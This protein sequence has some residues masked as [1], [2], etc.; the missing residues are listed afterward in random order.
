MN[1][2]LSIV[3][4]VACAT[5]SSAAPNEP[6]PTNDLPIVIAHR[7][8]SGYLPEHTL[9]AKSLAFGQGADFLEQDVVLSKDGVPVV[10]HDIYLDQVTDVAS[11]FADRKRKDGRF[12]AIDFTVAE[13]KE[14]QI[15]ERSS[16]D[17][18]VV[19]PNRFPG[20]APLKMNTLE[21]ELQLIEG[22]NRSSGRRIGIYPEIKQ[23][24][25]HLQQGQD[26]SAK[27]IGVLHQ[28]GYR[29]K[30]DP[31]WLQ[32]FEWNEVQRLRS[33]LGW[34][35]RLVQLIGNGKTGSGESD[36]ESMKTEEGLK[37]LST[38]VDA[39]GP[40]IRVIIRGETIAARKLS[41]FIQ[42][43]HRHGLQVH[44]FTARADAL[45]SAVDSLDQ[46]HQLLLVD[47]EADGLFTDF[48]DRTAEFIQQ[49]QI[50]LTRLHPVEPIQLWQTTPPGKIAAKGQER[51]TSDESSRKVE[52]R[53]VVRLGDISSPSVTIHPA[54]AHKNTGTTVVVC[55][56]GGYHI[57]AWN[58]EGTEVC[59]WLNSIGVNAALL[60]YRVPRADKD[61]V[62][63]EPLQD[64]QRAISMLRGRAQEFSLNPQKIGVL[65]FSAGGHLCARAATNYAAR[66]YEAADDTDKI[67]CRP[68]FA[69]LIYPAYLFDKKLD[70][71]L[72]SD[73]PVDAQTPP[74]FLTMAQDDPI[75]S[76]NVLSMARAL[77]RVKV[78]C[79]L[80][81]FP[82][83]GHGFGL[84]PNHHRATHWPELAT[85]WL[86][87]QGLLGSAP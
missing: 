38:V 75:D 39:V 35:G 84:R 72:A 60:K 15:R 59:Q 28:F 24:T 76:Q 26:L 14:L 52:G 64:L 9:A 10:S 63:V 82:S 37:Q 68:D 30:A 48:P 7:G 65:G 5:V 86:Q 79:E 34:Q 44:P 11:R 78:P 81:L 29:T 2:M 4:S 55:P 66:A 62:P 54:P 56:G 16:T 61:Q 53:W 73:L 47:A 25:W 80:H 50:W 70:G 18:T 22:L 83:G 71:Q 43:A 13:L 21:E 12:Y 1:R 6:L 41:D 20:P 42:L 58:L 85:N 36:F 57:L 19:M 31:C 17:G 45:P 69:L 33:Q 3:L 49:N 8:A 74:M 87:T 51:D 67:S 32:C 77:G 40:D 27:V 46:L 23:P